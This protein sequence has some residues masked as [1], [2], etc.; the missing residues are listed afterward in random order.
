MVY[1]LLAAAIVFGLG[2]F[3]ASIGNGMIFSKTIEGISR[4]PEQR[5]A[6]QTTAFIG[7]GLV[8]ALPI[9]SLVLAFM[10]YGAAE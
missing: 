2:A 6:L 9:I 1:G 5:S 10:F 8:E 3:G 7:V 4:Q